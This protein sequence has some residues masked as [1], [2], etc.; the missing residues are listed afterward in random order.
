MIKMSKRKW[1]YPKYGSRFICLSCMKENQLGAGIQRIHGQREEGRI[2]DLYCC[3]CKTVTKN[4]EI[5]YKDDP[6]AAYERAKQ[7]RVQYC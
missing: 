2:K 5:R 1:G 7:I 3:T 4:Y 6:D